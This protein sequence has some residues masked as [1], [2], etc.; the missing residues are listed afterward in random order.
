MEKIAARLIKGRSGL[1]VP[2]ST[3][4]KAPI[5]TGK[6]EVPLELFHYCTDKGYVDY[7]DELSMHTITFSVAYWEAQAK[8]P[9]TPHYKG[10]VTYYE[11][12]SFSEV[13]WLC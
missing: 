2:Q 10:V 9:R 1:W 8:S 13:K 4:D 12:D 5:L 7:N 6:V 11:S 3:E